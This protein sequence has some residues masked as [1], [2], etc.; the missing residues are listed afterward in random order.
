M[1]RSCAPGQS[2]ITSKISR[3]TLDLSS[4]VSSFTIRIQL[5]RGAP[6]AIP[7]SSQSFMMFIAQVLE[8]RTYPLWQLMDGIHQG[9]HVYVCSSR[10]DTLQQAEADE[11]VVGEGYRRPLVGP[12]TM[13][14]FFGQPLN[15]VN[16]SHWL[17]G[18]AIWI[19]EPLTGWLPR[20]LPSHFPRYPAYG[21]LI[22]LCRENLASSSKYLSI[23]NCVFF[24]VSQ[25]ES[26]TIWQ[27]K[28]RGERT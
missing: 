24:S 25:E 12:T 26:L 13:V 18:R 22:I 3:S 4:R 6:S 21:A 20:L 1:E 9:P 27:K 11:K 16:G 7:S 17:L 19:L 28:K 2:R 5:A 8:T 14:G 10:R 15:M 23:T